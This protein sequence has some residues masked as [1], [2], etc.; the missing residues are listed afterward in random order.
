M[1]LFRLYSFNLASC[2]SQTMNLE[3]VLDLEEELDK[4]TVKDQ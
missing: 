1:I 2:L 3:Q 4:D